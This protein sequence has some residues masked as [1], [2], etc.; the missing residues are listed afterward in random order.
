MPAIPS[1]GY[2]IA[3]GVLNRVRNIL[4]DSE[5]QGGDVFTDASVFA[6]DFLNN[7]YERVQ[8]QL[9]R[10]GVETFKA[11]WWLIGIPQVPIQDPEGRLIVDDTGTTI[12]YP[13]S[14]INNSFSLTPQLPTDLILPYELYERQNGTTIATG[15]AMR[16]RNGGLSRQNQGAFLGDWQWM[17]DGLYF[18]GAMQVQDVKIIGEKALPAIAAPTDP[19]PI[20]GVT[21]SAAY[22][23]ALAFTESRGGTIAAS[24]K[25][26]A[27]EEIFAMVN[28]SSRR[29]QHKQVRRRPFSGRGGRRGFPSI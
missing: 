20:R 9:A 17:S 15:P 18:R 19:V 7:G 5:V 4:N 23:T 26:R 11:E 1:S 14:P 8:K 21:N 29:R 6:F 25:D 3:E 10:H 22:Y 28:L 16:E 27:E 12:K 13:N 2:G 24:W